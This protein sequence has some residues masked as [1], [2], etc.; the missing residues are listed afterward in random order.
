MQQLFLLIFFVFTLAL[1]G[2]GVEAVDEPKEEVP[3][4]TDRDNDTIVDADDNCPDNKN[5]GQEDADEDGIG[6][7]CDDVD[8]AIPTT[9][10]ERDAAC[11]N[12]PWIWK[13]TGTIQDGS[14]Q[15]LAGAI[16]QICVTPA[17]G[18]MICQRPERS[19]DSGT[20]EIIVNIDYMCVKSVVM[21]SLGVDN[22]STTYYLDL[23]LPELVNGDN[24]PV[25]TISPSI[26]LHDTAAATV[27]TIADPFSNTE[28]YTISF[29]DGLEMDIQPSTFYG[30]TS[31]I[32][33][34]RSVR[35]AADSGGLE[36]AD[37]ATDFEAFYGFWPEADV[38]NTNGG[39]SVYPV[40]IPN[41]TGLANGTAVDFYVLG[42]LSTTLNGTIESKLHE[43]EW[44]KAGTGTVSG[45]TISSDSGSGLPCLT[46]FAYKAQ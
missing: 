30:Q 19:D 28:T 37:S 46:W 17:V 14:D 23:E 38:N 1:G 18:E 43:A 26:V 2:C 10:P 4:V 25:F 32:D 35:V 29:A 24:D 22:K 36:F 5:S 45:D 20:F 12:N 8:N 27:P 42:G 40:R 34:L 9:A 41:S 11:T 13:I 44:A 3:V 15:A 31:T 7:A 33:D 21:R 39:P 16:V 6:D